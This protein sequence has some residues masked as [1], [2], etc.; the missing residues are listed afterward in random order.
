MGTGHEGL[1]FLFS[2]HDG[3]SFFLSFFFFF[4]TKGMFGAFW[5]IHRQRIIGQDRQSFLRS[6]IKGVI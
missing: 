5:R 4:V 6:R 1:F 2:L 3:M